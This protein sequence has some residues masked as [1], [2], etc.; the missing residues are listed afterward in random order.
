MESMWGESV[1]EIDSFL[2]ELLHGTVKAELVG[3][4]DEKVLL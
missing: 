2:D 1:F 4:K 3:S